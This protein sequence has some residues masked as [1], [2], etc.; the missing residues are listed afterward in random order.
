MGFAEPVG[1][2]LRLG[3]S[4]SVRAS[5]SAAVGEPM[6]AVDCRPKRTWRRERSLRSVGRKTAMYLPQV[7]VLGCHHAA[8][9]ANASW[10]SLSA[11]QQP[12]SR[13]L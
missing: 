12:P 10:L 9:A 7:L 8:A 1:A 3:S 5:A 6:C 13:C 4:A 11:L 2:V